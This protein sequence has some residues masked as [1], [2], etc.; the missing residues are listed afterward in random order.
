MNDFFKLM[1]E[2]RKLVIKQ[3]SAKV[4]DLYPQVVEKDSWVTLLPTN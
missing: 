1:E 2:E 3:A 4:T